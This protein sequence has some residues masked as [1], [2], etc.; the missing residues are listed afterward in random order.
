VTQG[1]VAVG[2]AVGGGAA[3]A[4][5]MRAGVNARAREGSLPDA[6]TVRGGAGAGPARRGAWATVRG[7]F[8][9]SPFLTGQPPSLG[10]MWAARRPEPER[11][12]GRCETRGSRALRAAWTVWNVA[13]VV[14]L[15]PLYGLAHV[16]TH[17]ARVGAAALLLTPV[18]GVWLHWWGG[19]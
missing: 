14:V 8:T 2:M 5:P 11:V 16:L 15:A 13:A 12:P 10:R 3:S 1:D 4:G 17:P 18:V 9:G 7:D 19:G 6:V